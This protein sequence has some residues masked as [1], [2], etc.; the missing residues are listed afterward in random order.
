[1]SQS[2]TGLTLVEAQTLCNRLDKIKGIPP[3]GLPGIG[4]PGRTLHVSSPV[5]MADGTY[6]V[7][8]PDKVLTGLLGDLLGPRKTE[9]VAALTQDHIDEQGRT[10]SI[11]VLPSKDL[12]DVLAK[13]K[14][15]RAILPEERKAEAVLEAPLE[16]EL[17]K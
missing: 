1:M 17:P 4:G 2:A 15:R 10:V 16:T 12:D 6:S 9:A 13:L 8:L 3:E 11:K 5:P 7:P 14:A